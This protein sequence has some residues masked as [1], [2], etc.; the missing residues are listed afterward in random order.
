MVNY[1]TR[2]IKKMNSFKRK[3]TQHININDIIIKSAGHTSVNYDALEERTSYEFMDLVRCF[4]HGV[5]EF[6]IID[7]RDSGKYFTVYAETPHMHKVLNYNF[8]DNKFSVN[9]FSYL[10]IEAFGYYRERKT[11]PLVSK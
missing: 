1:I 2:F 9:T 7:M 10:D 4:V 3:R 11:V 8:A 5:Q 6:K